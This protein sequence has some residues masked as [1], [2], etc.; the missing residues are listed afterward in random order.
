MAKQEFLLTGTGGQ[1]LILAA[2]ML[3]E[4]GINAGQNVAQSQSYGPEA[5]GG[6]SRAEV[7]IG[8]EAIYYPKVERPD[9]VL[10]LSQEA[11]KKYGLHLN[12]EAILI[13]D[14]SYVTEVKP[15]S[16]NFY[17]L[18]ITKAAR[19]HFGSEQSSNVLA[20]GVVA[21]LSG[22]IPKENVL[23]AVQERAPKGTAAQNTKALE[24][25][26]QMGLKAG[27]LQENA[28]DLKENERWQNEGDV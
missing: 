24:I 2:I 19:V 6:A 14:D 25:G 7:I 10:T 18:P 16:R 26:W 11:Y 4:A 15:R 27:D 5:R 28:G 1:G 13:V 3:A 22:Q 9:F 21:S 23:Q 17:S 8:N 20:L 12:E